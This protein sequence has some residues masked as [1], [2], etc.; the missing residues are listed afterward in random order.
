M[1]DLHAGRP[2]WPRQRTKR[3]LGLQVIHP[4]GKNPAS[5]GDRTL[6]GH[7]IAAFL[8]SAAS[9]LQTATWMDAH[10]ILRN[11][12]RKTQ[13]NTNNSAGVH[14]RLI[15]LTEA[16]LRCLTKSCD[17][18]RGACARSNHDALASS[19]NKLETRA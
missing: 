3:R 6:R 7:A 10:F 1:L 14:A 5:T 17:H 9:I 4:R 8:N 11:N 12:R 18:P 19:C 16:F 2:C 15:R 13:T